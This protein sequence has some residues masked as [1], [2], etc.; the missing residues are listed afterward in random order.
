MK[1]IFYL[2]GYNCIAEI[3]K[4]RLECSGVY[5]K[6]FVDN[7]K[8]G[9]NIIKP[10]ELM[11]ISN[12]D[13]VCIYICMQNAMQHEPV[14]DMLY[15]MGFNY[16][17]FLP[18]SSKYNMQSYKM[19]ELYND[20]LYNGINLSTKVPHYEI[21]INKKYMQSNNVIHVPM[22]LV[23]TDINDNEVNK[24][25]ENK[26]ISLYEPYNQLYRYIYEAGELPIEY[27]QYNVKIT[28]KKR[29]NILKDRIALYEA[30]SAR[31]Y[32]DSLYYAMLT[33]TAEVDQMGRFHLKDGRH[34]ANLAFHLGKDFLPLV[35]KKGEVNHEWLND[36][37]K[38]RNY[39]LFIF[40]TDVVLSLPEM[41]SYSIY[42]V[43][44]ISIISKYMKM[45]LNEGSEIFVTDDI[46]C[47]KNAGCKIIFKRDIDEYVG[48]IYFFAMCKKFIHMKTC[49]VIDNRIY[50]V[51]IN[52]GDIDDLAR[53]I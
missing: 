41:M 22:E 50:H 48:N 29:K 4:K 12:K 35:V 36:F 33:C 14:A 10:S 17:V 24:K 40:L 6:S 53:R 43:D 44:N 42:S 5:V 11:H 28:G 52:E 38:E 16:I 20:I 34:R 7:N 37:M 49:Y 39:K 27:L 13:D 46:K 15:H 32:N 23:F 21:F 2:Y 26:H 1:M 51:H 3:V 9:I 25:W 47:M 19:L 31:M 45:L 30:L 8:V 18:V